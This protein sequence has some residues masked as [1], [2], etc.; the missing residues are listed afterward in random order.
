[1]Y[2]KESYM[3]RTKSEAESTRKSILQAALTVFS[4]KCYHSTTLEEIAECAKMT[5]GAVYWHFKNKEDLL[6]NLLDDFEISL[7]EKIQSFKND[8]QYRNLNLSEKALAWIT[9]WATT[10]INERNIF[11]TRLLHNSL[12]PEAESAVKSDANK[13]LMQ[14][15]KDF[16]LPS[17]AEIKNPMKEEALN[18][19]IMAI[20]TSMTYK[21][22]LENLQD[23]LI[24]NLN[25]EQLITDYHQIFVTYLGIQNQ[26]Q[27]DD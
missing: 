14:S 22:I 1:M 23:R 19:A 21:I 10:L 25:K 13:K 18:F 4:K 2:N 5:R 24:K 15:V 6:N 9:L 7:S 8:N 26:E 3:R 11:K 20:D 16:F 17:L 12:N 27:T